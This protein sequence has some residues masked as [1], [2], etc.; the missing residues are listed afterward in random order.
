[1]FAHSY[2]MNVL[3]MGG[4]GGSFLDL[5]GGWGGGGGPGHPSGS[6]GGGGGRFFW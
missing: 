6:W 3:D 4:G 5:D 2:V 1:M